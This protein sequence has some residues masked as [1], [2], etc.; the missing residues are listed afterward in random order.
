MNDRRE[1]ESLVDLHVLRRRAQLLKFND[2]SGPN[3]RQWQIAAPLTY[4]TIALIR[5]QFL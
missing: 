3:R 4:E 1:L 2:L 5:L